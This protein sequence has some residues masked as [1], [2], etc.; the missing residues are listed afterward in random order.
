MHHR[1]KHEMQR[2]AAERQRAA[3]RHRDAL[4]RERIVAAELI[5]NRKR[6]GV[7][8][9]LQL[10]LA[11]AERR[12]RPGVIRLHVR[13]YQIIQ[14]APGQNLVK[15][16]QPFLLLARVHRIEQAELIVLDQV[17]VI[18]HALRHGILPLEQI[19]IVIHHAQAKNARRHFI[20]K[21]CINHPSCVG[22][23][24]CD[25]SIYATWR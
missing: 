25:M 3:V 24:F 22:L 8:D 6:S 10:R 16:G 13:N 1:R 12:N 18:A 11:R 7:G 17:A 4:L 9:Q 23:F 5:Q 20:H 15:P 2:M 19:K 14:L 21:H